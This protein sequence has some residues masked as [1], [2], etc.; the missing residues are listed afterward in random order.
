MLAPVLT[1]ILGP[2]PQHQSY[3]ED[4]RPRD[5]PLLQEY[6]DDVGRLGQDELVETLERRSDVEEAAVVLAS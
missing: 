4:L 1:S 5:L 2:Q 3:G 6:P